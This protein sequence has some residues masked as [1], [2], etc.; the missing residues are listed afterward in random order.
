MRELETRNQ[1][2]ETRRA[3]LSWRSAAKIAWRDMRS[4]TGKFLFV[5]L[6]VA[7]GVA[8]LTGVRGFSGAFRQALLLNARSIMA[9]DISARMFQQPTPAEQ[10]QLDAMRKQGMEMTSVTEMVS[11]ASTPANPNPLLVSLKA[12]N[13]AQYPFY[14]KVTVQPAGSLS[15]LLT[16]GTVVVGD[17]LLMRLHTQVGEQLKIGGRLFRIAGV[18][19]SEPDRLSSSMGLGPRVLMTQHA[20]EQTDLLQPGSRS[21]QRYL[22]K[23]PADQRDAVDSVKAKIEQML[24]EAQVTDFR[25]TNPA[26]T[27][28]LDRSTSMLSLMSLVAM[29]LGALGVAMAMRAHLQQRL[30]TIA[31]MKSMGA[32]SSQILRIY[33]LQTLLLGIAGGL[34]GVMLGV[35]VQSAFPL[36]LKKYIALQPDMHLQLR[37]ILTGIGT[38]ILTT[39]L[40]TLPPLLDIRNVRPSLIFRRAVDEGEAPDT[41]KRWSFWL[42]KLAK[43]RAQLLAMLLILAGLAAIATTLSDS[44]TVGKWF[45]VGLLAALIALLGMSAALLRGLRWFLAKTRLHLPSQVR[46]GLANLYRPGNQSAAV[47]AALGT[48][49]MLIL[50]VFLMQQAVVGELNLTASPDIPNVFLVDISARELDGVVKLMEQQPGLRGPVE[51]LPVVSARLLSIDGVPT[52]KLRLEHYPRRMLQSTSL[53]WADQLPKGT[54]VL[55]GAWWQAGSTAPQIAVNDR[56]AQRLHLHL[57]S[58]MVLSA[59]VREIA[60]TV[61]ALTKS[62]GQHAYSRSSFIVPQSLLSGFPTIW[63]G[64]VHIDPAQ[65]ATAQRALYAAYPTITVINVADALETIRGVVMQIALVVQFLAVFSIFAGIIILASSIAG[66]RYRRTREVVVLKTLGATRMRIA[67]VFSVEFLVLGVVAGT[68]GVI[69]ANLLTH[70]LLKR[71]DVRFHFNWIALVAGI[72][73]TALIA[74]VTGWLASY[75]ILGQKPLEV[76]REE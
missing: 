1:N 41:E 9:A 36:L 69:F 46:H 37:A 3:T 24:P 52:E 68:V 49:V 53:S 19:V 60:V 62:D 21:A 38:G 10:A 8:A 17:D 18:V 55:H 45:A 39:L 29:V 42:G 54:K 66:T 75:R 72:L 73:G 61:V 35:G 67:S 2:A 7:I 65:V 34:L 30:D 48:G 14:G 64:A 20:L 4:S 25:E 6:S 47:L 74:D 15:S 5:A 43:H 63:Y 58:H 32:R 76:L 59:I 56:T 23:L 50:T 40:F 16:D 33:L 31:I 71:M 51:T 28:G 26:L 27:E 12:V 44:A 70:V 13:P 11:M 57:G 22:F